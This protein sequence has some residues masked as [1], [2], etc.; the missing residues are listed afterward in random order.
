MTETHPISP[1]GKVKLAITMDDML[2]FRGV[3]MPRGYSSLAIAQAMTAALRRHRVPG[4][5]AFSNTAPAEDNPDLL[6]VFDHWVEQGH[7]IANHTHHHPSIN[8]VD[9]QTYIDDIERTEEIIKRW[10]ALAP[11]RYFR[12]C[13]D[14]WGDTP[15]KVETVATY[16]ARQR[17][18]AVPVTLGFRDTRFHPAFW[19][20]LSRDDHEGIAHL[21]REFINTAVHELRLHAAN[22]RAVFGRDPAHIW[23]IHGTPLGGDCLDA[24]LDAF[25]AAGVEFISIAEAMQDPMNAR[26]PPRV[27]PEFIH[28][29]EKWALVHGVPV[30]DRAPK[31]LEEIEKLNVMPGESAAEI[32][33]RQLDLLAHHLKGAKPAPVPVASI[34]C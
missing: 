26:V 18:T 21:R 3:P 29:V 32:R 16:L 22:A 8:W 25:E 10:S 5:Y 4:V 12:Y 24:I 19:R 28:Q 27:S 15:E 14:M 6:R 1:L 31:I 7:H 20:A 23:L 13:M 34:Q 17:Y 9:A 11:Q 2:L 30:D 33:A